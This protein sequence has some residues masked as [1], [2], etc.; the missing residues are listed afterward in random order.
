[1]NLT[2]FV[3]GNSLDCYEWEAEDKLEIKYKIEELAPGISFF[4]VFNIDKQEFGAVTSNQIIIIDKQVNQMK[5]ISTNHKFAYG[6]GKDI[7]IIE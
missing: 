1:M 2:A 7:F 5:P 6:L 3:K 4:Q